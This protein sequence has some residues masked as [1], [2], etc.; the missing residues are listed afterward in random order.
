LGEIEKGEGDSI[1]YPLHL[2]REEKSG[3]GN[4]SLSPRPLNTIDIRIFTI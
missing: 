3:E 2:S 1:L 4:L